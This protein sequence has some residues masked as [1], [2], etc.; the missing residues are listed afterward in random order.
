MIN[1]VGNGRIR[2]FL[3]PLEREDSIYLLIRPSAFRKFD[4][5]E[6]TLDFF[7]FNVCMTSPHSSAGFFLHRKF[8]DAILR[9]P[10]SLSTVV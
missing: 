8:P 10:V 1:F 6:E 9:R 2:S 3:V 7:Y 4:R 5:L